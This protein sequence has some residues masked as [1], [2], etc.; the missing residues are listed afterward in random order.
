VLEA[1]VLHHRSK[2]EDNAKAQQL[3]ARAI[4]LD[5]KYAHAH[6]W[7]ACIL[8]QAWSYGWCDDPVAARQ[9]IE[10][11]LEIAVALDEN[12]SDVQRVFAALRLLQRDHD[13][14]I[15]HQQRAL[16]L[17]PNDDL[18]V[19]QQGELLTWIGEPE[20]GIPWIQKAMRL[21]PF[22]P[23][24]FWSH[25]GRAYFV[26]RR[27]AEAVEAFKRIAAPDQF[28]YAF[29]AACYAQLGDATA[30][31]KCAREVLCRN[32]GFSWRATLLPVLYYQRG[33]DIAHHRESI[34]KAGL[35]L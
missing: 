6:A 31:D 1:K 30:A 14:A 26:A 22:H 29:L 35:P 24:R 23:P 15:F 17:N 18:V 7:K 19:V 3:I 16:S 34:E 2:R 28:H 10:R 25:L 21:N 8:G 11:E 5:P 9:L 13:R 20:N 33:S 12:D 4:E 27:Y 32:P